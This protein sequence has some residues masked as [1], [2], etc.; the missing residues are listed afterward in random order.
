MFRSS[1]FF[2]YRV[3]SIVYRV[4]SVEYRVSCIEYRVPTRYTIHDAFEYRVSSVNLH[5]V[6]TVLQSIHKCK[7]NF[8]TIEKNYSQYFLY[9]MM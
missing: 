1:D 6:G 7:Y 2:E 9:D 5:L 3:S 8:C 4:S